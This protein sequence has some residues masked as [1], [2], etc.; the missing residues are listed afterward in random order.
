MSEKN[1]ELQI[2]KENAERLL[3]N[4]PLNIESNHHLPN[5]NNLYFQYSHW[6]NQ[7]PS[8]KFSAIIS[9][10]AKTVVSGDTE[11]MVFRFLDCK[12]C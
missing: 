7:I 3:P 1:N 9:N 6:F 10:A 8:Q 12:I 11:N 4:N 5:T 2:A